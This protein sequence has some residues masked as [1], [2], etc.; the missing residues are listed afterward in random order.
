LLGLKELITRIGHESQRSY[1]LPAAEIEQRLTNAL[2]RAIAASSNRTSHEKSVPD[3][4]NEA[5]EKEPVT[6]E[7]Q[8]GTHFA[9]SKKR[10]KGKITSFDR[11]PHQM[12]PTEQ[13]CEEPTLQEEDEDEK[14]IHEQ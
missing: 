14:E 7:N 4:V 11:F 13:G 10:Q 9:K 3:R 1:C 2:G 12:A 5:N 8:H 6:S